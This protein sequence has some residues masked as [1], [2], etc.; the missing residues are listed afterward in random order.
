MMES[1]AGLLLLGLPEAA[2][3]IYSWKEAHS[4]RGWSGEILHLQLGPA[5]LRLA[6]GFHLN[7]GSSI[8]YWMP[9]VQAALGYYGSKGMVCIGVLTAIAFVAFTWNKCKTRISRWGLTFLIAG[10]LGNVIDR[11]TVGGVIDYILLDLKGPL[12]T[13]FFWNLSD[14]YIDFAVIFV[15]V[16]VLSGD[17]EDLVNP[18]GGEAGAVDGANTGQDADK[19]DKS[20]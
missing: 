17:L 13:S 14:L 10:G 5:S 20:D 11:V 6:W 9:S 4:E 8:G 19:G 18:V 3:K 2:L 7:R 15:I 16:A 12:R 1:L